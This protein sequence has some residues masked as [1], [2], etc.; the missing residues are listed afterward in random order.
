MSLPLPP[1]AEQTG[2]DKALGCPRDLWSGRSTMGR[3]RV[4]Y[5]FCSFSRPSPIP[6]RVQDQT[7]LSLLTNRLN[8]KQQQKRSREGR[9]NIYK[10]T[11]KSALF[12]KEIFGKNRLQCR[13]VCVCVHR[14]T[15]ETQDRE[16]KQASMLPTKWGH[17]GDLGPFPSPF[18][19]AIQRSAG[20]E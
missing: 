1:K 2:D 5:S 7:A 15:C 4:R 16:G 17:C 3:P 10:I 11:S 19:K 6:A 12:K 18:G 20:S 9:A 8:N 14:P 13:V